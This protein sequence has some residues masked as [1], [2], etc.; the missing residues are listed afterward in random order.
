MAL[1]ASSPWL[2]I[3]IVLCTQSHEFRICRM[4]G[5]F[6]DQ[7]ECFDVFRFRAAQLGEQDIIWMR[8][9]Q[10][11]ITLGGLKGASFPAIG[12]LESH[13]VTD[14]NVR[15]VFAQARIDLRCRAA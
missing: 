1:R 3:S 5:A 10:A 7:T 8:V 15:Q 4:P 12:R 11:P 2:K 9:H 14:L 13:P 6:D